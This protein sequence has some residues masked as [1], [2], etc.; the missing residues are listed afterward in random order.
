MKTNKSTSRV[1][2]QDNR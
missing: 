2:H 1:E